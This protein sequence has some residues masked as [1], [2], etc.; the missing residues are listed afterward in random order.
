MKTLVSI[1]VPVYN[2]EKYLHRCLD[3]LSRQTLASIEILLIDDAS[4]D[5]CGII[6][7]AYAAKDSRFKVLHNTK[8]KGLAAVRNIGVKLASSDYFMF[9][10]SDDWVSNNCCKVVYE[11]AIKN[12]A[13][14]VMF[15]YQ[16][17]KEND[18]GGFRNIFVNRV[19]EGFKTKEEAIELTYLSYGMVA[20]NKL[21]HRKLFD[22][23]TY[24]EG[25]WFEDTATTYKLLWKASKIYCIEDV[26]YYYLFGRPGSIMSNI[27]NAKARKD[28]A[29]I[30]LW[31]CCDLYN[32]GYRKEL[33]MPRLISA[34]LNYCLTNKQDD[35][36]KEYLIAE[37]ILKEVRDIPKTYSWRS[38]VMIRLF[39]LNRTLFDIVCILFGKRVLA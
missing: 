4:T 1:I 20:W 16:L 38:R 39:Q 2:V 7:E 10:D 27:K 22:N 6:C 31:H 30:Q 36:D 3:S 19:S 25:Y 28:S 9:V 17:T 15:A 13:D 33:S 32:W 34:A 23:V 26:L 29:K 11:C 5:N 14:I 18:V 37:K 8:N 12:N 35:N 24:P 21:Y